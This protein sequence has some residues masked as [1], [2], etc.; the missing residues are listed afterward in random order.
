MD[1]I[2]KIAVGLVAV[3]ILCASLVFV[4]PGISAVQEQGSTG[5]GGNVTVYFFYG[6]EC[7]HCH[8]VMPVVQSLQQKY[9]TVDFLILETWH[10]QTN[11]LLYTQVNRDLGVRYLAVP[12]AV[13]GN[14]VLFGELDIPEKL[15]PAIIDQLKKKN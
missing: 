1:K 14:V 6:E 3:I 15:E 9:P 8:K 7:L 4:Y 2:I 11:H 5:P 10:N 12:E 13:V